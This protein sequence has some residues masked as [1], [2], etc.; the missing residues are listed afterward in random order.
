MKAPPIRVDVLGLVC[1]AVPGLLNDPVRLR[2]DPVKRR[3]IT[4]VVFQSP[5]HRASHVRAHTCS[6]VVIKIDPRPEA[7]NMF[8]EFE[9]SEHH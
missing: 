3:W 5:V 9:L 6:C 2:G 4:V 1:H 8:Q 7:K